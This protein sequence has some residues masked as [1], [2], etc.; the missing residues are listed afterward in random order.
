LYRYSK[1]M[2]NL[3]EGFVKL[4][5]G[6]FLYRRGCTAVLLNAVDP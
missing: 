3:V 2:V 6:E 5:A 1:V 4:A